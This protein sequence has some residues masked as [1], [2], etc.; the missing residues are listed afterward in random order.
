MSF[1]TRA[2]Y[3]LAGKYLLGGSI[4]TD[5]SS[6][7]GT[8]NRWGVFPAVSAA[9]L[10]SEESFLKGSRFINYMKLRGSYGLTGNQ[11]IGDFPFQGLVGSANYGD[12]AG[13]APSNLANPNLK[14]ETTA[15]FD[16]GLDMA[17]ASGRISLTA[18]FYHKNT[19]DLLVDRPV[20]GT[21]GFTSVFDNVG[22]LRNQGLELSLTTVNA[23]SRRK[24][25]FRWSTTLNFALNRNRVTRLFNDQPF[26]GGERDINR[27]EVGQ[28]IGVFYTLN[29]LGVD[30]ATGDA[31]YQDVDGDGSITSADRTVV[32]NPHPNF[33]GG[34]TN[35]LAYRGFDLTGFLTFSQGNDVFN[36]M[37]LFSDAG[38]YYTDNQF[39]EARTRWRNPGDQTSEPRASYDGTSGAREIS[40]RF[41][42]DGSYLRL[43]DLT[44]GYRLPEHFAGRLG[45]RTWRVYLSARNLFT[46]TDYKGYTPDVNSN[47]EASAVTTW[48]ASDSATDFYAYPIART[49][50]FGVQAGW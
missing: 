32:G 21:S 6:R 50:T 15:Q 33:T 42:E 43:Q 30:P 44:L 40:S 34:L 18:D 1:F 17:L 28:P 23:E 25:G 4:R 8:D 5:G 26:T 13:I 24:D 31:I 14:W 3:T 47:G 20:S 12:D 27:V 29:F 2:N 48:P 9:W 22:N 35:T 49:F 45:F 16:L 39:G 10:L 46:I 41:I 37:R 38:G 7:F 36:A 11:P 19:R